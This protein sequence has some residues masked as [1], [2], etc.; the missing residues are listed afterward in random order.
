MF[1]IERIR[2]E[3]E[4]IASRA[5]QQ[6][7]TILHLADVNFGMFPRDKDI[8]KTL[9]Q[10]QKKYNWPS[11]VVSTTGKNNK[12]RVIDVTSILGNTFSVTMSAQS[13]DEK[14]L[15]NIKRSNIKL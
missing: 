9:V 7:N 15:S 8:C 4:Y 10:M 12:E 5:S 3:L 14:V 11:T 2:K 6:K 13:M 1:S